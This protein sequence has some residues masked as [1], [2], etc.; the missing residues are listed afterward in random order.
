MGWKACVDMVSLHCLNL[1]QRCGGF[2]I[3][4]SNCACAPR[5][6]VLRPPVAQHSFSVQD[7]CVERY[8]CEARYIILLSFE[9]LGHVAPQCRHV[10]VRPSGIT[11]LGCPMCFTANVRLPA[12]E[13]MPRRL[14][15][16]KRASSAVLCIKSQQIRVR[17]MTQ[18]AFPVETK[19]TTSIQ[20]D[21]PK[22]KSRCLNLADFT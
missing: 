14:E 4:V 5:R 8:T 12:M 2:W 13:T 19:V 10:N 18:F 20:L 9:T 17:F 15:L 11:L 1:G 3:A 16:Q 22:T 21:S 7:Y 6:H